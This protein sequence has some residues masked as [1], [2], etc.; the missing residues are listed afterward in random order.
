[1]GCIVLIKLGW[2]ESV[3]FGWVLPYDINIHALQSERITGAGT[4]TEFRG[5]YSSQCGVYRKK[6]F[7]HHHLK[8]IHF[9]DSHKHL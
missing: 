3:G 2:C 9:T 7:L 1:M 4:V 8:E 6:R 5:M